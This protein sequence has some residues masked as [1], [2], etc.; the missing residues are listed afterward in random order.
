M[1]TSRREAL[2]RGLGP[3]T[4]FLPDRRHRLGEGSKKADDGS[5]KQWGIEQTKVL[6]R[7]LQNLSV[8]FVDVSTGGN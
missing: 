1:A 7:E 5:W 6:V 4:S 3:E 2:S 8:D